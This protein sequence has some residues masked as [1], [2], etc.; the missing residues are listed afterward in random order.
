MVYKVYSGGVGGIYG[1]L[2]TVEAD[3]SSGLP[4]FEMIGLLGSEV[5]E[6]KERV[7]VALHNNGINL[8]SMHITVNLSP[9]SE[10]KSGAAYD[11]PIAVALLGVFDHAY[12][13]NPNNTLV[14]G[15]LSLDGDILPVSGIL[16]IVKMAREKGFKRVILP[17]GNA[18]E[19]ALIRD[20]DIIGVKTLSEVLSYVSASEEDADHII[21]P[22]ESSLDING[23]NEATYP[24]FNEVYGQEAAKR[25]AAIAVAGFHH[26]VMTGPPGTGKSL[27][28]E[29]LPGIMPSLTYEES[30]EVTTLYSV[31]GKVK[32]GTGLIKKRPFINPHHS[33]SPQS[34]IGGGSNVMPGLISLSHKGI[35]F[36]DE[37]TEFHRETIDQMRQ[38]LE[39]GKITVSR[40]KG[41]TVYPADFMLV[42]AMNP[43]PCGYYPDRNRCSCTQPQIDRY[44]SRISGPIMDR[45]DICIEVARVRPEDM[46]DVKS[47]N[48]S[49]AVLK[50]KVERAVLIQQER[51]KDE[52][53]RFNA[54]VP[55]SKCDKYMPLGEKEKE[56]IMQNYK[57]MEL[58]M[59]AFYKIIRVARTIADFDGDEEIKIKHLA[60]ALCYR[61]PDYMRR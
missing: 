14:I 1:N 40:I 56:F 57:A 34:L 43:C 42:G 58:S 23:E 11:L 24:D 39:E 26:M 60:E 38:P 7:K 51:Y 48:M 61:F 30:L 37:M 20:I 6:A 45:I 53:F 15:E 55:S 36:L 35:L 21:V 18:E 44:L 29:R 47:G 2:I 16:P 59:R 3:A 28:A 27:I 52:D 13:F 19:G 31:S 10:R 25:A 50:E 46:K 33:A 41:S 12:G 32:A 4:C 22:Y 54:S 17:A 49:S 8:P 9:A 5:R